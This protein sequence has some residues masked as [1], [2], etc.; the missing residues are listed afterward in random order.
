MANYEAWLTDDYG[1]RLAQLDD[2]LTLSA[3]RVV[4][5]IGFALI[6]A[7]PTFDT[8]LLDAGTD[9]MFQV[10][11]APTGGAL[12]L[13]RTYLYR[14]AK[15]QTQGSNEKVTIGGPCINDLLRRRVTAN[16]S[17]Q[18]SNTINT[19]ADNMMK[20]LV[21]DSMSDALL[22]AP[23]AGTRAWADLSVAANTSSGPI[24]D[25]QFLL[26]KLLT[27]S[28]NGGALTDIAKAAEIAGTPVFF[29][30]QPTVVTSSSIAFEFRTFIDQVGVDRTTTGTVFD[31]DRGTLKDPFLEWDATDEVNYVYAGGPGSGAARNIQQVSDADRYNKSQWARCE[32]FADAREQDDVADR[33]REVGRW[34]LYAGRPMLKFGGIP[35]DTA[36]SRFG[37]DWD[38]GDRIPA[39]YRGLNF[40]ILVNAV[41]LN[42]DDK[43]NETIT[44]RL[45]YQR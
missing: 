44:T 19:Y 29:D 21:T 28:G 2:V 8:K 5:G 6:T 4:N 10:W 30:I 27:A 43:G 1:K 31:Q 37:I 22:L 32:G 14:Y 40:E 26:Q 12:S 11:R 34:A 35:L 7:A 36:G 13:W 39:R 3:S 17:D 42:V 9:R 33:V 18:A 23:T 15:F 24:L 45:D 16:Y 20:T 38:F 25:K 41:T